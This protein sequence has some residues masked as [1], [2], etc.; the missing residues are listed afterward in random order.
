[1]DHQYI[2]TNGIRLHVLQDGPKEGPLVILLH[3]FPEFSYGWRQQIPYLVSAGYRVWAPDQRGYN[4]SDKPDGLASY[5][6]DELAADVVGLIDAAGQK[7]VFLVGHDWGAAVAWWVAAKYPDRLARMVVINGPPG[8]VMQKHIR[9]NLAQLRKIWY[10]LFFQIPRI[11]EILVGLRNW[12]FLTKVL[13]DS[14]HQGTFTN[15]DL[16]QYREAWSQPKAFR[17]ML[18]WY[19]AYIQKPSTPPANPRITVPTLLI[20]GAQD[21]VLG[22]EMAQ[23]SIDL[24]DDGRLVFIE[25][26]THWVQHEESDRVNELLDTFLRDGMKD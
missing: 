17:S 23:P 18:N 7:Q 14:S 11:P 8:A 1:M 13:R 12:S 19:R 26:A 4:L 10:I 25:E 6:L 2:E 16:D 9:S 20:W 21:T 24:C 15:S 3:G 22:R 5:S